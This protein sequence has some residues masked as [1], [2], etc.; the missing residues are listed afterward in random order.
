M[1]ITCPH[2]EQLINVDEINAEKMQ[3][4][5]LNMTIIEEPDE[6]ITTLVTKKPEIKTP[7]VGDIEKNTYE[8][9][10][11]V[12]D[13]WKQEFNKEIIVLHYTA[14]YNW[15]GAYNTFKKPGRVATPFI[16][17]KEGPKY[18]VKLFDEKYWSYHLGIKSKEFS[19]NWI[20]DKRSIGIEIVNIGTVWHEEG[21]WKDYI[22]R[23]EKSGTTSE[24][25]IIKGNNRDADGNVKFPEKQVD[26]VCDL[27]NYLCDKWNI[28]RQVPKDK[29]SL[30]LPQITNFKG[31][32]THQMFRQD[33][34]DMGVAWPWQKM[35]ERCG[36]QEIEI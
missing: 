25:D 32:V 6:N 15:E 4:K 22:Q 3:K 19:K 29:M 36:L 20:N 31:I 33:K 1:K 10:L 24:Q 11:P 27:V 28:P 12:G 30:Q 16:I 23:I 35:I 18:I 17:D 2:C 26:A 34:Y 7:T 9:S 13:Y 5:N 21:Q 8:H 14:G